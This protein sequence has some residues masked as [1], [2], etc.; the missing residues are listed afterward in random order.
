MSRNQKV[1][2]FVTGF[3]LGCLILA[4]LP[5][6]RF[7]PREHPWHLQT[8]PEG[9]YPMEVEDDLGRV[10]LLE[11][12]PRHFIS[13]APSIT[14]ILFAMGMGDHLMAVTQWCTWPEAGRALV[15]AGAHIGSMDQP[16]RETIVAYRPDLIIG[17]HL[18]PPEIYEAL[19]DP[20]KRVA[21]VVRH[22]GLDDLLKDIGFIGTSL[23]VPGKALELV[24]RLE[25]RRAAIRE[26]LEPWRTEPP[27]R[28]LFLLSIEEDGSPG[29]S[30]GRNTWISD[31][32]EEAHGENLAD[33]M[34][35]SWGQVSYEALVAMNPEVLLIRRS[36]N[37]VEQA[38]M[39]SQV[40][41]LQEHPV[42]GGLTAVRQ[43]R[44]H[45]IP[46]EPVSIPGP[47]VMEGLEAIAR[48]LWLEPGHEPGVP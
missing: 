46:N 25:S 34:G 47:R 45:W 30:P 15:E 24:R 37:P 41:R 35:T 26:S 1:L 39:E 27:K 31:L 18:T 11:R 44:V 13:L 33:Q 42:W 6:E 3:L 32:V 19:S 4:L 8:A 29:W 43:E 17:T 40:A 21:L 36:L 28:V 48:A 10:V 38:R 22:D 23:G 14:E 9:T 7:Q 5:R 16:N 20:P 2:V 12:Q